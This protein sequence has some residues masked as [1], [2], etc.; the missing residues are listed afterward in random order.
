MSPLELRE[1]S[2]P[3]K[4]CEWSESGG[5]SGHPEKTRMLL[6]KEGQMDGRLA[7]TRHVHCR[8]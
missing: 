4:P 3:P 6:I 5:R 2:T 8:G 1:E 7:K